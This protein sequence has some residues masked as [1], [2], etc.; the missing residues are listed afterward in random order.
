[1][2]FKTPATSPSDNTSLPTTPKELKKWAQ[3]LP[4]TNP[5]AM[6]RSVFYGLR[7]LNRVTIPANQ[8]FDLMEVL[9]PYAHIVLG[10]LRRHFIDRPLPLS[11]KARKVVH[12]CEQLSIEMARGYKHVLNAVLQR[13]VRLSQDRVAQAIERA[14]RY[15]GE[16][17]RINREVYILPTEEGWAD[18][19]RLYWLAEHNQLAGRAVAD[20]Q[21]L[22]LTKITIDEIYIALN[23]LVICQPEQ[24]YQGEVLRLAGYLEQNARHCRLVSKARPDASGG[25][26]CVRLGSAEGPQYQPLEAVSPSADL[27]FIDVHDLIAQLLERANRPPLQPGEAIKDKTALSPDQATRLVT[28]LTSRSWRRETRE[29]MRDHIEVAIGLDNIFTALQPDMASGA[30]VELSAD[31]HT[32]SP[33]YDLDLMPGPV[34]EADDPLLN[35]TFSRPSDPDIWDIWRSSTARQEAT[36]P[37]ASPTGERHTQASNTS[38][39]LVVDQSQGGL[40]LLWQLEEPSRALVGELAGLR[41]TSTAQPSWSINVIRW[42]RCQ[43]G[44]GM[45]IGLQRLATQVIPVHVRFVHSAAADNPAYEALLAPGDPMQEDPAFL[46]TPP[47]RFHSGDELNVS[48][49]GRQVKIQLLA[50]TSRSSFFSQYTY[51]DATQAGPNRQGSADDAG[52][53]TFDSLWTTL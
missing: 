20:E 49:Y 31:A 1:M 23:L 13:E 40:R 10:S 17:L 47:D 12:L 25:V 3:G 39:W 35:E 32:S 14:L 28:R 52:R 27:R 26:I 34:R 51:S 33:T 6:S 29:P 50:L 38:T 48:M 53:D 45:E 7:E 44:L 18:I 19:N 8:R 24:L 16:A 41:D 9:R 4:R 42:L 2:A 5:G 37:P 22:S 43:T 15:H 30:H 36:A 46:L 11:A 21:L